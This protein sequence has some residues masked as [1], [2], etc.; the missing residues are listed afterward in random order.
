MANIKIKMTT[1]SGLSFT[2]LLQWALG[3]VK[4]HAPSPQF[5]LICA[6]GYP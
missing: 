6:V 2:K 1:P 5:L 4:V 3:D